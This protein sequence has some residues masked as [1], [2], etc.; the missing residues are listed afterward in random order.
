MFDL[1]LAGG[2]DD[3]DNDNDDNDNPDDKPV[4]RVPAPTTPT[5]GVEAFEVVVS[6]HHNAYLT[7]YFLPGELHLGGEGIYTRL[8]LCLGLNVLI[9]AVLQAK[10]TV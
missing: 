10:L 8:L 2:G 1:L 3:D 4:V 6:I 7:L 9:M 5:H